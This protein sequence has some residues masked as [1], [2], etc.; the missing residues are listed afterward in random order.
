MGWSMD[1]S[2]SRHGRCGSHALV[3]RTTGI[4]MTEC[5]PGQAP[6]DAVHWIRPVD[7]FSRTP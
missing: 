3:Q 7:V 4:C 1:A 5:R 6:P 2:S